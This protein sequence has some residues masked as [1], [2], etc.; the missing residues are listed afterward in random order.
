MEASGVGAEG[1]SD[2]GVTSTTEGADHA[3]AESG[4]HLHVQAKSNDAGY[5]R[6]CGRC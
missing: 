2:G 5:A 6:S 1:G 4:E 3:V